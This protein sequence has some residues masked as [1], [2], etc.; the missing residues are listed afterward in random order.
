M[1]FRDFSFPQVQQDLGVAYVEADL[2]SHVAPTPVRALFAAEIADAA[3]LALAVNT[4]K[5]KSG[6]I[7]APILLQLRR[8]MN[9]RFGL[10][11]GVEF[12]R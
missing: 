10:F 12:N 5:A 7:I 4:E 11:S 8:M 1:A 9:R 6:F 2:F 3:N